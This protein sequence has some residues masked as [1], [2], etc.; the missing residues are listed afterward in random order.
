MLPVARRANQ[1]YVGWA[2]YPSV[3]SF[4]AAEL[5]Q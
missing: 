5:M 1:T 2:A 3:S 4:S